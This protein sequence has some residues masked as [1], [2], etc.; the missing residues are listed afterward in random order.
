MLKASLLH[1]C[2]S[3]FKIAQMVPN[4]AKSLNDSKPDVKFQIKIRKLKL[5]L[6]KRKIVFPAGSVAEQAD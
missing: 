3:R 6:E 1:T 4:R 5:F 2:F